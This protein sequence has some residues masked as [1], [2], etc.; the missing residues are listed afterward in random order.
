V[1]TGMHKR[2]QLLAAEPTWAVDHI[3][4]LT[5]AEVVGRI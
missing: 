5:I 2:E 3:G 1:A 4:Q